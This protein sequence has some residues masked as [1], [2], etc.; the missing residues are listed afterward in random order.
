MERNPSTSVVT[1]AP[2]EP[3][4]STSPTFLDTVIAPN[5]F[6]SRCR[7][8]PSLKASWPFALTMVEAAFNPTTV[9]SPNL[10]RAESGM[11]SGIVMS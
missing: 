6:S 2:F 9:M 7:P 5:A 10:L 3:D 1:T 8:R 11:V 4:T